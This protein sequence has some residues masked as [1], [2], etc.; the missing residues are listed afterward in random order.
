MFELRLD[1]FVNEFGRDADGTCCRG[2]KTSTGMCSGTCR[3]RFRVCLKH[4][5]TTIDP[6]PPC[7]YGEVLTPV[8][9]NNSVRLEPTNDPETGFA[10][11]IV[12]SFDFSWVVSLFRYFKE[13]V[14]S[15][16]NN[17]V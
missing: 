3:T 5:Q 10:N 9:G 6:N 17:K 13:T 16:M 4:Y 15:L 2:V 1:T 8:L 14:L 7:T 11:P 12:F